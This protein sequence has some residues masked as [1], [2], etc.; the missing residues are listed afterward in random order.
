M[1]GPLVL[2]G[3]NNLRVGDI[4]VPRDFLSPDTLSLAEAGDYK[5]T[6]KHSRSGIVISILSKSSV[7]KS[8]GFIHV[9]MRSNVTRF[10]RTSAVLLLLGCFTLDRFNQAKGKSIYGMNLTLYYKRLYR[11]WVGTLNAFQHCHSWMNECWYFSSHI[12]AFWKRIREFSAESTIF[13]MNKW[14]ST[15]NFR[16]PSEKT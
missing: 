13:I 5:H 10:Q 4:S 7:L 3:E 16:Q 6:N 15:I 1:S 12:T 2:L 8:K 11:N 9:K 14:L